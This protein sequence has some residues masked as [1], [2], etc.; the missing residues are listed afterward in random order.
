MVFLKSGGHR[1]IERGLV[2]GNSFQMREKRLQIGES[3][4]FT[5][6]GRLP[7]MVVRN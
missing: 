6:H 1:D 2:S 5:G 4:R 3:T 7:I